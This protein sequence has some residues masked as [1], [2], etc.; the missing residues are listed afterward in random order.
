MEA[1]VGVAAMGVASEV[2]R[3][4][5]AWAVNSWTQTRIGCGSDW[6]WVEELGCHLLG[7]AGFGGRSSWPKDKSSLGD[8]TGIT[9]LGGS[10]RITNKNLE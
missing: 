8:H 5:W 10:H 6:G 1:H 9:K 2:P 3:T 7:Q 4:Q